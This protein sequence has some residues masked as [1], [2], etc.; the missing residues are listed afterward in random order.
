MKK[1]LVVLVSGSGSNLQ[2]LID[3]CNP[4]RPDA[5]NAVIVAVFSNKEDAYG[6]TRAR[7]AGIPA[8]SLS[9]AQFSSRDTFDAALQTHIDDYQPDLIILAGYMR[10]LSPGFVR[11]YYGRMLNIHPSLL[12]KYPGLHTH[13][14]ALDNNDAE[15]G[16]SVHFVTEELDGGPVILQARI[17]LFAGDT[18][19]NVTAR[20]QQ[21]EYRIYP[22]VINWFVQDRLTLRDDGAYLDGMSLDGISLTDHPG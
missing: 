9:P 18:E 16:T 1:R 3:A 12:P 5:I 4:Q 14:K 22:Q 7:L 13:R 8:L 21:E 6:L 15:H 11:H 2:A 19:E 20:V 10:I 17:P